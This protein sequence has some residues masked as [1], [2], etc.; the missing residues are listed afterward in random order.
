[1]FAGTCPVSIDLFIKMLIGR[2]R[3]G[4]SD[5]SSVELIPSWPEL[6]LHFNDAMMRDISSGSVGDINIDR[7]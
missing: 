2:H 3:A 4:C 6:F 1:M 7:W 5:F